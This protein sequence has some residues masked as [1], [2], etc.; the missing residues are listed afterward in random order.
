MRMFLG[1]FFSWIVVFGII[2]ILQGVTFDED[3]YP[4]L[5]PY[6]AGLIQIFRNSMGDISAPKYDVWEKKLNNTL[7]KDDLTDFNLDA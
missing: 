3:D 7:T 2:F 4:G 1:F 6:F 5:C